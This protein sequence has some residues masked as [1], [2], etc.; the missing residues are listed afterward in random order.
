MKLGV[1]TLV[2]P[3]SWFYSSE[4]PWMWCYLW[5][6]P[7]RIRMQEWPYQE[8][9]KGPSVPIT[10]FWHWPM[11]R[12]K[13]LEIKGPFPS[14]VYRPPQ[15]EVDSKVLSSIPTHG[16][17]LHGVLSTLHT[18]TV[19][20]WGFFLK[21]QTQKQLF[22]DVINRSGLVLRLQIVWGKLKRFYFS[23]CFQVSN[24]LS[25]DLP[26]TCTLRVIFEKAWRKYL[27]Y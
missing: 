6:T 19:I 4:V 10:H 22:Q 17:A 23:L 7:M 25:F 26:H 13:V 14:H 12:K 15:L 3:R 5:Q 21:S 27:Y 9:S 16:P 18:D 11:L 1:F 2:F 20:T 24:V 8:R